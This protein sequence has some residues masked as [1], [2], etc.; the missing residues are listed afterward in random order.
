MDFL[1]NNWPL[2]LVAFA[3]GGMLVWP[4]VVSAPRGGAI[5]VTEAVNLINREKAVVIDISDEAEFAKAHVGGAKNVPFDQVEVKLASV[6]KN[7]ATPV[8][9]VCAS[10]SRSVKAVALAKKA[11]FTNVQ[12]LNGGTAGWR[13]A[14][15]PIDAVLA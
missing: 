1:I 11:G 7:K 13:A 14:S 2:I 4:A 6:V 12:S 3:A 15:M 5:A 8:I 9:L 10:G